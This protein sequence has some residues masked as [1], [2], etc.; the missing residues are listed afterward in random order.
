MPTPRPLSNCNRLKP[1]LISIY[2]PHPRGLHRTVTAAPRLHPNLAAL[3]RRKVADL[4][5]ALNAAE[6]RAEAAEALRGLIDEIVLV[7][8]G[9]SLQLELRGD[10]AAILA[11]AM[12]AQEPP[13]VGGLLPESITLVAGVGFEPTTFRL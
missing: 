4:H 10:L 13:R 12:D 6:T 1:L 8:E 9:G 3:Y 7:P 5:R 2:R 11:L